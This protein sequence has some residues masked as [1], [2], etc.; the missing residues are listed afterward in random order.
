MKERY[1]SKTP[2]VT[3]VYISKC[4]INLPG[5]F[6]NSKKRF[7]WTGLVTMQTRW[8][9]LSM[10]TCWGVRPLFLLASRSAPVLATFLAGKIISSKSGLLLR[11][12]K[13]FLAAVISY[14]M[15]RSSK[16]LPKHE[17]ITLSKPGVR[18][19]SSRLTAFKLSFL[20]WR[21]RA[22]LSQWWRGRSKAV[23]LSE[24]T[25]SSSSSST[26]P[27]CAIAKNSWTSLEEEKSLTD[28]FVCVSIS[29]LCKSHWLISLFVFQ[30][31]FFAKSDLDLSI[32]F[33]RI[34]FVSFKLFFCQILCFI[35]S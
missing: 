7:L 15:R 23:S 9:A 30:Y 24:Q 31:Y 8:T 27:R 11:T 33:F 12:L 21:W 14:T 32:D 3:F 10:S 16:W 1:L 28:F 13:L 26:T 35:Q 19:L 18:S 34:Y 20:R 2:N 4:N 22:S 6:G 25:C 17:Q 5:Y 29:F